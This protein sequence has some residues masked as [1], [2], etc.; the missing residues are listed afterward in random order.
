MVQRNI[1]DI[2]NGRAEAGIGD[3]RPRADRRRRVLPFSAALLIAA[4]VGGTV[5][6]HARQPSAQQATPAASAPSVPVTTTQSQQQ[7]VP[8]WLRGLGTVQALNT[9]TVRTRVDGTL[10]KVPVAEGQ[11]VKQGTLL[12]VIDPRPYEVMLE[13]AEGQLAHDKA[14]MADLQLNYERYK[15]L[16][17]DGVIP[18]QQLDTQLSQ[19]G[20]YEG[21]IKSDQGQIDNAKLQLVYCR[22]LSEIDGRVG[23]LFPPAA[24]ELHGT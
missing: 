20:T 13:Q 4:G 17:K 10:D 15:S 1:E 23:L 3:A 2:S 6:L 19:V 5:L 16:Y 7:D 22:I 18:K 12:A 21:S 11:L 24:D 8:V 14:A 9:V